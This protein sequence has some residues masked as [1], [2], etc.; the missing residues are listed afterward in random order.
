M[1]DKGED[2]DL[3][4]NQCAGFLFYTPFY[5][6]DTFYPGVLV[7]NDETK[8]RLEERFPALRR[9]NFVLVLLSLPQPPP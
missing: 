5:T 6:G 1:D 9:N 3:G 8:A 7:R 2:I 4:A